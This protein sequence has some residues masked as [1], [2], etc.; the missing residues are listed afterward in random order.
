MYTFQQDLPLSFDNLNN[1]QNYFSTI[2]LKHK[3]NKLVSSIIYS[4][5]NNINDIDL[6]LFYN[7]FVTFKNEFNKLFYLV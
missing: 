6:Q 2:F 7:I 3:Q 5:K 1:I 4:Y